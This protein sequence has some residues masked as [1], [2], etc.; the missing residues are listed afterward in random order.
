MPSS[1]SAHWATLCSHSA[2]DF[3]RERWILAFFWVSPLKWE[4]KKKNPKRKGGLQCLGG[5]VHTK[6][7][8]VPSNPDEYPISAVNRGCGFREMSSMV[9]RG[10]LRLKYVKAPSF[11]APP[12]Q[13]N[14][15]D[16]NNLLG[17]ETSPKW[18]C[19][20]GC[21]WW[22]NQV[23]SWCQ[24]GQSPWSGTAPRYRKGKTEEQAPFPAYKKLQYYL[25]VPLFS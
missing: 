15:C 1:S 22:L 23:G 9:N 21:T 17:S 24:N 18:M 14:A 7:H 20:P 8:L 2:A 6:L 25:C 19:R 16:H 3:D 13:E 5:K 12:A 11:R 10:G 4:K